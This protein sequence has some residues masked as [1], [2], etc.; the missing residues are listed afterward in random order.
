M[1]SELMPQ[2]ADALGT[3]GFVV[4]RQ[5]FD[6]T[7]LAAEV[8]RALA[9]G[10]LGDVLC[11]RRYPVSVRA[12]DDRRDACQ[13]V[14]MDRAE[15]VAVA[16]FGG[17]VIP[18]RAKGT[19]YHGESRGTPIPICRSGAWD[20]S[21]TSNRSVPIAGRSAWFP[22]HITRSS[23][24]HSAESA[25]RACVYLLLPAHV[26]ATEPGD[27]VVLDER[28]LHASFGGG[29][30]RQWRVDFLGVPADAEI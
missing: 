8:A 2:A 25:R 18:T 28:V 6:P 21:P 7:P 22:V 12:D 15:S 14:I 17:P 20:F 1:T 23:G 10:I 29:I 26:V 30:R 5:L 24:R 11:G 19:R 16:V 4:L 3:F 9:D 13:S 27:M